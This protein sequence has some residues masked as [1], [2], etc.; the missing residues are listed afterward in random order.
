MIALVVFRI[1]S[2]RVE[3]FLA[4]ME[5]I[6]SG[7]ADARIEA[8]GGDEAR[9]IFERFNFMMDKVSETLKS[10]REEKRSLLAVVKAV[11]SSSDAISVTDSV[12]GG[13]Y[14]N[15]RFVELFGYS[16]EELKSSGGHSL[17]Y[18]DSRVAAEIF[19]SR[20]PWGIMGG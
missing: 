9:M 10:E 3:S 8:H 13:K 4:G 16:A 11:D 18:N 19:H 7:N 12:N 14:Y 5:E 20:K 17:I 2:P 15:K 1:A 6:A